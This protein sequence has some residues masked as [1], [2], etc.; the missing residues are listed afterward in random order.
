[1]EL[2]IWIA[3]R[4][5]V[6]QRSS[7]M[8]PITTATAGLLAVFLVIQGRLPAAPS[9]VS[10]QRRAGS[11]EAMPMPA[12]LGRDVPCSEACTGP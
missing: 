8:Q 2:V 10:P 5:L 12:S 7:R 1:M 4:V 3:D 11:R 9:A 6:P